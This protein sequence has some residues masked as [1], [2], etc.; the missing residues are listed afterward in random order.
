MEQTSSRTAS[1]DTSPGSRVTVSLVSPICSR[2]ET[3]CREPLELVG[4]GPVWLPSDSRP[5]TVAGGLGDGVGGAWV[6]AG[7]EGGGLL[8]ADILCCQRERDLPGG[9]AQSADGGLA[10]HFLSASLLLPV[11]A[12]H[13]CFQGDDAQLVR[14]TLGSGRNRTGPHSERLQLETQR[15]RGQK[16]QRS[17]LLGR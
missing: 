9:E 15:R 13:L 1:S 16:G 10:L 3:P 7:H 17:A 5:Q 8:S 12:E 14:E 4:L 6:W 2:K 11:A